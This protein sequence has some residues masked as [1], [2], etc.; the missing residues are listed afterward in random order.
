MA[1]NY[2]SV[3]KKKFSNAKTYENHLKRMQHLLLAGEIQM[4]QITKN[5]GNTLPIPQIPQNNLT[6][7]QQMQSVSS[8]PVII[9]KLIP[10]YENSDK[11]DSKTEAISIKNME[12][13]MKKK[14]DLLQ[15]QQNELLAQL[16]LPHPPQPPP[17]QHT[18]K[19]DKD[20]KKAKKLKKKNAELMT[21]LERLAKKNRQISKSVSHMSDTKNSQPQQPQQLQQNQSQQSL[22]LPTESTFQKYFSF[23]KPYAVPLILTI[24]GSIFSKVVTTTKTPTEPVQ[25]LNHNPYSH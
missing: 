5:N 18:E 24:V 20:K 25:Q 8:Q 14:I 10:I 12:M 21:T 7:N 17:N 1:E 9:E 3:C 19:D 23:V 2:C 16:A 13:E 11:E 15:G 6:T 22:S 4:T